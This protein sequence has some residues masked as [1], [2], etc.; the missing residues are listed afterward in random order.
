MGFHP[1]LLKK[2]FNTFPLFLSSFE[3]LARKTANPLPEIR[4]R[5][6]PQRIISL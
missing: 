3:R 5:I 1:R 4:E 6:S 2:Y